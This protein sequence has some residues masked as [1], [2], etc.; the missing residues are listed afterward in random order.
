MK[1]LV[2]TNVH[3]PPAYQDMPEPQAQDNELIVNLKAGSLNHRDV[4]ITKGLYPHRVPQIIFGSDGAGEVNG[5][6]VILNPNIG[7]GDNDHFPEPDYL[8]LGN[9][10][11]GTFAEQIAVTPDRLADM[12]EHLTYEQAAALPLAGLTAYRA[13]ISRAQA[14]PGEKVLISGIGGGVALFAFQF[15][16]AMG[17]EVYVT[18]S[19][20]EKISRA[21]D[22][23]G[24][25][26]ANYTEEKW[27]K[28]FGKE[29]G[30]FDSSST[31]LVAPDS[32]IW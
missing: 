27:S 1:A 6:S 19:S 13:L 2:F 20:A 4:W 17:C 11:H 29:T 18:S 9:P 23:G 28:P 31:V 12:P 22:M 26:G 5:R 15:A 32:L 25:G 3:E 30:G 10:G 7:W 8:I 16:V 24:R 21:L 14:K